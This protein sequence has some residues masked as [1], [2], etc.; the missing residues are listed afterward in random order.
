MLLQVVNFQYNIVDVLVCSS[1]VS[2]GT[3][4]SRPVGQSSAIGKGPSDT[5]SSTIDSRPESSAV[6]GPVDS[7][8]ESSPICSSTIDSRPEGSVVDSW[9]GSIGSTI[10]SWPEAKV[11]AI[12]SSRPV[13]QAIAQTPVKA[14][15]IG[16]EG[17]P[18]QVASL[19]ILLCGLLLCLLILHGLI[20]IVLHPLLHV[21]SGHL[22][23]A[24][25][26]LNGL[27]QDQS[28]LSNSLEN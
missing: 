12:D 3:P 25:S 10:N 18:Q 23:Q 6:G 28:K 8:P 14:G 24:G 19:L 20:N 9:P 13:A 27:G 26:V 5:K 2:K 22:L 1:P 15:S 17:S 4:Q 16:L 21:L 11:V 7:W